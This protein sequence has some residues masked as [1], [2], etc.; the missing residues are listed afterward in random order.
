MSTPRIAKNIITAEL[1]DTATTGLLRGLDTVEENILSASRKNKKK[2]LADSGDAYKTELQR[3]VVRL[4]ELAVLNIRNIDITHVKTYKNKSAVPDDYQSYMDSLQNLSD[5]IQKD[6]VFQKNTD[7]A[8]LCMERWV[9]LWKLCY[10]EN[11]YFVAAAIIFALT[12][13]PIIRSNLE[14][15]LSDVGKA[16]FVYAQKIYTKQSTIF[17]IQGQQFRNGKK[18]IPMLSALAGMLDGIA[19]QPEDD[20]DAQQY[21]QMMSEKYIKTYVGMQKSAN[22][23]VK[24]AR[25]KIHADLSQSPNSALYQDYYDQGTRVRTSLA[26]KKYKI[27]TSKLM[28]QISMYGAADLYYLHRANIAQLSNELSDYASRHKINSMNEQIIVNVRVMLAKDVI[29]HQAKLD[30]INR[31]LSDNKGA[32]NKSVLK[33]LVQIQS[34]LTAL[35]SLRQKELSLEPVV[36]NDAEPDSRDHVM[37][38]TD[39]KSEAVVILSEKEGDVT[40]VESLAGSMHESQTLSDKESAD[41]SSIKEDSGTEFSLPVLQVESESKKTGSMDTIIEEFVDVSTSSELSLSG[42]MNEVLTPRDNEQADI[43][44]MKEESGIE[45]GDMVQVYA[46]SNA[47]NITISSVSEKQI[48]ASVSGRNDSVV[49]TD[50][51]DLSRQTSRIQSTIDEFNKRTIQPVSAKPELER[52]KLGSG[53]IVRNQSRL[54]DLGL[55]SQSK[56]KEPNSEVSLEMHALLSARYVSSIRKKI[57]EAGAEGDTQAS[58]QL[59]ALVSPRQDQKAREIAKGLDETDSSDIRLK[60]FGQ[61]RRYSV[62]ASKISE[63]RQSENEERQII[64]GASVLK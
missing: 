25:K 31:I 22:D 63:S 42:S 17:T 19:N 20:E 14:E 48:D 46:S 7:H 27:K 24:R 26:K 41:T 32:I 15:K 57:S 30:E 9:Y 33:I 61:Q 23:K 40:P 28:S 34:E 51:F 52:P 43:E 2:E 53:K 10:E 35:V 39:S 11:N 58:S 21:I 54:I 5:L 59:P 4:R 55:F 56:V 1:L 60:L 64:P 45:S 16:I 8:I 37:P 29:T 44:S 49:L 6:I 13:Q 62:I 50:R 36:T 18:V 47:S 12:S 38:K 3:I